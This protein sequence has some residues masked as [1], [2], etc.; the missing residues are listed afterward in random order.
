LNNGGIKGL[1]SLFSM[2]D[3]LQYEYDGDDNLLRKYI[4]GP[5]IDQPIC[6]DNR[7][8]PYYMLFIYP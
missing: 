5:G 4:Y 1:R 2:I 6:K 3:T 7:D 8:E